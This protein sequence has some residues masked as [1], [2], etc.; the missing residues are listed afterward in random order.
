MHNSIWP[1]IRLCYELL[2]YISYM[3]LLLFPLQMIFKQDGLYIGDRV[4]TWM[5]YVSTYHQSPFNKV[6]RLALFF[7]L[8]T[9]ERSYYKLFPPAD[10]YS[11]NLLNELKKT[12][13]VLSW[14]RS[15][16]VF[17]LYK[18]TGKSYLAWDIQKV[19]SYMQ[20]KEDSNLGWFGWFGQ[21]ESSLISCTFYE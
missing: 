19:L 12:Q 11:V 21:L 20:N 16:K 14:I 6:L 7:W 15:Q 5:F 9:P 2:S 10:I 17:I 8:R 3:L 4:A 18:K 13:K 1:N